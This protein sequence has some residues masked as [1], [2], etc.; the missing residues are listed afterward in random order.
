MLQRT[1][2]LKGVS[3]ITK[4]NFTETDTVQKLFD[5]QKAAYQVEAELI[6]FFE[7]PR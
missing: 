1:Y 6:N 5:L 4:I 7:I 2:F 3:M